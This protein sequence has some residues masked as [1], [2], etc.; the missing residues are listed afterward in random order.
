MRLYL[1]RHGDAIHSLGNRKD[2]AKKLSELGKEQVVEIREIL[3]KEIGDKPIRIYISGA[4]RTRESW[5][6]IKDYLPN[7]TASFHDDL[8]LASQDFLLKFLWELEDGENHVL[9]L[10]HNNGLSDLAVYLSEDDIVL[11]TAGLAILDFKGLD[12]LNEVSKGLAMDRAYY[13][14]RD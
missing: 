14:P 4:R 10:G 8:Y 1:L 13:R 9:I 6:L 5:D 3:V 2:F 12:N 11:P 7:A